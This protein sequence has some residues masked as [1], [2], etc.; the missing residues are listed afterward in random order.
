MV[1]E[2]P[3]LK[4]DP[5]LAKLRATLLKEPQT[6]F[7]RLRDRLQS[8][9]ETTPESLARLAEASFDLGKL[10]DEIGDKQDALRAFEESL[11]IRERLAR[12]NPSV[13]QFQRDLADS[14][15]DIGLLQHADGP[16]GGGARVARAGPRNL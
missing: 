3:E 1:R 4:N 13:T 8:D 7:K 14:H 2:T 12:E 10:T 9:R 6:F 16:T 15:N 5:S 11:V